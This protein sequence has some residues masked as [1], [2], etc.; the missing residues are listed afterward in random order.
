M[1]TIEDV[2]STLKELYPTLPVAAMENMDIAS[3]VKGNARKITTRAEE[4]LGLSLKEYKVA[5]K[6]AVDSMLEH[7]LISMPAAA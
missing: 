2:F 3:G 6:D 7:K 1:V 5:L 4:G